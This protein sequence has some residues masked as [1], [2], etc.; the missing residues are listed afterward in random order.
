MKKKT[1]S[2]LIHLNFLSGLAY[3]FYHFITTPRYDLIPRRM[4]A[5]E[6]W[7]IFGFYALYLFLSLRE[8][9]KDEK[10]FSLPSIKHLKRRKND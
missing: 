4:W 8:I 10:I 7:I 6:C 1:L 9:P 3:A 2:L 5:Y